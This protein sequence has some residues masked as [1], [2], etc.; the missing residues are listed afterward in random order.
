MTTLS[1]LIGIFRSGL[2]ITE[3][4]AIYFRSAKHLDQTFQVF[5]V[6]LFQSYHCFSLIFCIA[7]VMVLAKFQ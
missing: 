1:A 4:I 2:W 6:V 5:E 3:T 7:V